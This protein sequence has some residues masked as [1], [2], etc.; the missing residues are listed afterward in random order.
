MRNW[1]KRSHWM[2]LLA[3]LPAF[4]QALLTP[5]EMNQYSRYTQHRDIL[6]FLSEL[7]EKSDRVRIEEVGKTHALEDYPSQSLLLC[8]VS[9]EGASQPQQLDRSKPTILIVA[10]QHGSEQSAKEAALVLLRDIAVGDLRQLL[11]RANLLIIPQ[12]N[13]WGNHQDRRVN[14]LGLDMNR[15]HVKLETEGAQA[16]HHV[17][18]T[19]MPE[20]TLDVHERGDNFYRIAMGCVSN[21]N[22]DAAIQSFSRGTILAEVEKTLARDKITFHEYMVA[23]EKMPNDASGANFSDQNLAGWPLIMR[24]STS[25]LNDGRNSLGI[26]QTYAFIQEG[27]SRHDLQTLG[28]RTWYQ[29]RAIRAFLHS[30]ADHGAEILAHVRTLRQGVQEQSASFS[31]SQVTHLKMEYRRDPSQPQ[32]RLQEFPK[33]DIAIAGV[34]KVDKKAGEAVLASELEPQSPSDKERVVTRIIDDWFPLVVPTRSVVRPLGYVIPAKHAEVIATLRLHDV[35]I[36]MFRQDCKMRVEGYL[37]EKVTPSRLDY[38]PP[39]TLITKAQ[40]LEI[41]CKKGDFYIPCQQAAA[42]LL[43]CL[44]EPESDYGFIR[45]RKYGLVPGVGDYYALFRNVLVQDLPLTSW[46]DW[47]R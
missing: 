19:W 31:P 33:K 44:L 17:F 21:A 40:P 8:I 27:A 24:Y 28:H 42:I 13:P 30:I 43:P 29:S 46:C 39:D 15:D 22:V 36:L 25:D 9:E 41:L 34:L 16:I 7:A 38:L 3:V 5:G 20:V 26:Y 47:P 4:S 1:S 12:A 37:T 18:R 45:Y 10:S 14:E 11:A 6:Q 23:S 35:R 32:V 2:I